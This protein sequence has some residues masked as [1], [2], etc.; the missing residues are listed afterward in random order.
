MAIFMEV[1]CEGV[2]DVDGCFSAQNAGSIT[3]AH[4]SVKSVSAALAFLK[5]DSLNNGWVLHKGDFYCPVC[6]KAKAWELMAAGIKV[7]AE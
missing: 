4:E 1:R 5:D 2:G 7:E 3:S 6:A